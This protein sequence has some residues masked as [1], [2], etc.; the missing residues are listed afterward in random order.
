M[1][2]ARPPKR[3]PLRH[4]RRDPTLRPRRRAERRPSVHQRLLQFFPRQQRA[5][6][7]ARRPSECTAGG[8]LSLLGESQGH[9]YWTATLHLDRAMV[10]ALHGRGYTGKNRHE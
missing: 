7:H 10:A 8:V 5:Q 6:Q 1:L 2:P 3:L 9:P 4:A